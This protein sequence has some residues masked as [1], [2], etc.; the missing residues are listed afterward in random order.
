MFLK[1]EKIKLP[2]L[3]IPVASYAFKHAGTIVYEVG[4]DVDVRLL[5]R[6]YLLFKI[7]I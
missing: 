1:T 3:L 7:R 6:D 4:H 2:L 5:E